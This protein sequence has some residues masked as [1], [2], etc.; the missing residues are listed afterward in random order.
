MV[1]ALDESDNGTKQGTADNLKKIPENINKD[2]KARLEDIWNT[3]Y[4]EAVGNCPIDTGSLVSTIQ[5][6][7]S[8]EDIGTWEG[9]A[10][11]TG[12]AEKAIA[13]FNGT[14][15]AGSDS[16]INP[17]NGMPTSQ[18][19]AYV[20]DGH[21]DKSGRWIDEQP[22]LTDAFYNHLDELQEA[23]DEVIKEQGAE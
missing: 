1:I 15:T 5:L 11:P 9:E 18:Y 10:Q 8:D 6:V 12:S 21:F 7:T 19:A 23:V 4:L 13:F 3:I 22:F 17:K 16:V 20:H 14:I 2:A